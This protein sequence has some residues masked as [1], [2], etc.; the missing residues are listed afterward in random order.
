MEEEAVKTSECT[1]VDSIYINED[2]D[3]TTYNVLLHGLPCDHHVN[4][5]VTREQ[6]YEIPE[7]VCRPMYEDGVKT[8]R[9]G[10]IKTVHLPG[11][12][13]CY[14]QTSIYESE[15]KE[16]AEYIASTAEAQENA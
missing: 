7:W 13:K 8:R 2:L 6:L 10:V 5:I 9:L 3:T 14:V 12:N 16:T 4:A 1:R 11:L 15:I